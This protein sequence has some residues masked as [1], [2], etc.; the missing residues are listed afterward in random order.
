M[1]CLDMNMFFLNFGKYMQTYISQGK[2]R[3]VTANY[4]LIK[5]SINITFEAK[6]QTARK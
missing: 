1:A 2:K 6:L 4:L 5:Y 3:Q